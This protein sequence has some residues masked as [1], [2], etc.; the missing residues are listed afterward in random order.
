MTRSDVKKLAW[1]LR[2]VGY[3]LL[4]SAAALMFLGTQHASATSSRPSSTPYVK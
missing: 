4:M 1:T 2:L 3:G